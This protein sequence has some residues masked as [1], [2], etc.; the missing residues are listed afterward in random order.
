MGYL[1]HVKAGERPSA[2]KENAKIDAINGLTDRLNTLWLPGGSSGGLRVTI[3]NASGS[4]VP[5]GGAL[6]VTGCRASGSFD[7]MKALWL[8]GSIPLTGAALDEHSDLIAYALEGIPAGEIGRAYCPGVMMVPAILKDSDHQWIDTSDEGLATTD[9]GLFRILAKSSPAGSQSGGSGGSGSGESDETIFALVYK[10]EGHRYA[11]TASKITGPTQTANVSFA[12][13]TVPVACP[14]MGTSGVLASGSKVV[15]SYN[16]YSRKWEIIDFARKHYG[17]QIKT[18]GNNGFPTQNN[19]GT[20]YVN[21]TLDDDVSH[22]VYCPM[23]RSGE[24]I[25]G[26]TKVVIS[27]NQASSRYEIIEAQCPASASAAALPGSTGDEEEGSGSGSGEGSGSGSGIG[28]GSEPASTGDE[29]SGEGEDEG[30]GSGSGES[31]G[32]GSGSGESGSGEPSPEPSGEE[33][34]ESDGEEESGT[35]DGGEGS[36]TGGGE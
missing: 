8:S 5:S 29:G 16:A 18:L 10:V 35:G 31:E 20:Q 27:Y 17:H 7:K 28:S 1:P 13:A 2:K 23:L 12:G 14:M 3:S 6:K 32:S 34:G 24:S 30:S 9:N 11:N 33:N 21:L 25:D 19:A 26:N 22:K 4:A 15:V 36:G